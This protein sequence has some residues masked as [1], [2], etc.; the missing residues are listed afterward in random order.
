MKPSLSQEY[1]ALPDQELA[2]P[3][4]FDRLLDRV[5]VGLADKP[6]LD[7]GRSVKPEQFARLD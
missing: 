3:R 5:A 7:G 6:R 1:G 2:L 4:A